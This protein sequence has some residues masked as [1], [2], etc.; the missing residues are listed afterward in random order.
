MWYDVVAGGHGMN[1]CLHVPSLSKHDAFMQLL[2]AKGLS[3]LHCSILDDEVGRFVGGAL[4]RNKR[5]AR[6]ACL[7]PVFMC[8]IQNAMTGDRPLRR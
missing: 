7:L 8:T 4:H 3:V 1:A 2:Q 5:G 6:V